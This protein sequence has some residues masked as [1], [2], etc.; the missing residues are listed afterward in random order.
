MGLFANLRAY[1]RVLSATRLNRVPDL[2]RLLARRPSIAFGVGAYE[3]GLVATGRVDAR[4]K[5]LAEVRTSAL[6]GCPF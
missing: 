3:L 6:V 4:L 1:K 2:V 5:A